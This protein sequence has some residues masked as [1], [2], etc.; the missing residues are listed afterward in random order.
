MTQSRPADHF[1]RLYQSSPDPWGFLTSDYE[2]DKYRSSLAALGDRHY[3]AALEVGCS[4]GVFTR[5]LS[6]RCERLLGIDIV[7]APLAAA[8]AYCA[9]AHHV[10]FQRMQ[11]PRQWP[12]DSFDLIVFSEVLYFLSPDDIRQCA[13]RVLDTLLPGG[14]VLLVNWTGKSSDPCTGEGASDHFIGHVE[15]RLRIIDAQRY[16]NYRLERLV[17]A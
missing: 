5:M 2:Q 4:I 16:P 12:D 13:R 14:I 8:R 9:D 1:E 11:V 17:R 3:A 6:P 7:D 15:G 10:R